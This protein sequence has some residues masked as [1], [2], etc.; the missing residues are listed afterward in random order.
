MDIRSFLNNDFEVIDLEE[1]YHES[2]HDFENMFLIQKKVLN[3]T[4]KTIRINATA[5]THI[6]STCLIIL[7]S[8]FLIS[9]EKDKDIKITFDRKSKIVEKLKK[10]GFIN[11]N[12]SNPNTIPLNIV[13][14]EDNIEK[15]ITSL[16]E[17]SPLKGLDSTKKDTLKSKL[18]EIPN[19][20]LTHSGS[21]YGAIYC[22]FY[23]TKNVFCF[24]MYDLGIGIPCSVRKYA[25]NDTI[26]AFEAINWA[27]QSGN[28]T[29]KTD[30][31]R[32]LGFTLLEE[33]RKTGSGKISLISEDILYE[34][35]K[36]G[37]SYKNMINKVPGT[38]FTIKISV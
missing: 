26:T 37:I 38:L 33:F 2:K 3:S 14:N 9:K 24:S 27:L 11:I 13:D 30:Y 4:K 12:N 20:A 35:T 36:N 21:K 7:S 28:T 31:T 25:G 15:I 19:N 23:T 18:Y 5:C 8:I 16:I 10:N 22:G 1:K 17:L 34:S 29:K 32:G 6:S